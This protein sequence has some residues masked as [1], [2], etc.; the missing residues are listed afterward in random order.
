VHFLVAV[1]NLL[2]LLGDLPLDLAKDIL[3]MEELGGGR[4]EL[5]AVT[6]SVVFD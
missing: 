1:S 5:L 4:G 2:V 6:L 3:R